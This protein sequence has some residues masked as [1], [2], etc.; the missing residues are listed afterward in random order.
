MKPKILIVDD[1]PD[2]LA[3]VAEAFRPEYQ[4]FTAKNGADT[5]QIALSEGPAVIISDINM[6]VMDG[7]TLVKELRAAK[8]EIPVIL[9]TGY[10]DTTKIRT[11]WQNGA[12]DFISKPFELPLLQSIVKSAIAFGKKALKSN[13]EKVTLFVEIS[14]ETHDELKAK[15]ALDQVSIMELVISLIQKK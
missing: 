15:A 4:V 6:P 5:L 3:L 8:S 7:L 11:A 13:G 2:L 9:M 1:D 12:F 10:S 14:K